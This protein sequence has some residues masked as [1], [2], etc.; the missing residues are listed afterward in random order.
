MLPILDAGMEDGLVK[1]SIFFWG[2]NGLA[3]PMYVTHSEHGFNGFLTECSE[4]PLSSIDVS[5]LE[6]GIT[7]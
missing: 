2:G 3:L 5:V 1:E 6:P 4:H 7:Q